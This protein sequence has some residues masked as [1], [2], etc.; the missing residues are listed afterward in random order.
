[1]RTFKEVVLEY[2]HMAECVRPRRQPKDAGGN[3]SSLIKMAPSRSS[4]RFTISTIN[5]RSMWMPE[6]SRPTPRSTV[7]AIRRSRLGAEKLL[8]DPMSSL[9]SWEEMPMAKA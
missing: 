6:N 4:G 1:M 5:G 9:T 3:P 8:F 2:P 7:L